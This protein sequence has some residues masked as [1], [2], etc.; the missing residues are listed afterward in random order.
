M[1]MFVALIRTCTFLSIDFGAIRWARVR[2]R[3]LRLGAFALAALAGRREARSLTP[4][5]FAFVAGWLGVA[6][7]APASPGFLLTSLALFILLGVAALIDGLYFVL[8]DG[9]LLGLAALGALIRVTDPPGSIA[10]FLGA[11]LCAYAAFWLFARVYEK[12]SGR[13]GLGGGDVRL[14][15]IAGLWLGGEGLVSCLL[16]AT[17]SAL[18]SA[19][20]AW[21]S[22]ELARRDDPLPF[23][24]HIALGLWLT[25]MFGPLST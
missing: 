22:G 13:P 18:L 25:W 23:G 11:G 8:P 17:G 7:G 1:R 19:A 2:R 12:L 6:T 15:A 24:P 16:V 5:A 14:F 3:A 21:R 4:M 20:L 9:P 10:A